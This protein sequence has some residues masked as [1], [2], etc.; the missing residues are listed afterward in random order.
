M[1]CIIVRAKSLLDGECTS[2]KLWLVDLAGSERLQ[3]TCAQGERLKESQHINK[4]LSA[5]R[6]VFSALAKKSKHV[7]YRCVWYSYKYVNLLF[8]AH[9]LTSFSR[10]KF[11]INTYAARF[12]R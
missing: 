11:Q 6:D 1:A 7:P 9:Y 5:L 12:S 10:Q 8:F 3:K 4:S 2:S